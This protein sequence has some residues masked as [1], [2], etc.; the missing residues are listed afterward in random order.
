MDKMSD[1]ILGAVENIPIEVLYKKLKDSLNRLDKA[2]DEEYKKMI[3]KEVEFVCSMVLTKRVILDVG[4]D[5]M[6]KNLDKV[7]IISEL[8]DLSNYIK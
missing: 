4:I 7:G 5:K 3:E 1:L 6:K 2:E 8:E